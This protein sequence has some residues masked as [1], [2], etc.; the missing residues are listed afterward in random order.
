MDIENSLNTLA[1]EDRE[2]LFLIFNAGLTY[3]EIES[4]SGIPEG[5]IKSRVY[6]LKK[7]LR[8]LLAEGGI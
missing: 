8:P 7:K 2:L 6:Y 4:I 5:T 1:S 3:K